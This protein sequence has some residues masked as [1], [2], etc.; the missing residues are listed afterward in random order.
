MCIQG[1]VIHIHSFGKEH[2]I[3]VANNWR[4]LSDVAEPSDIMLK[5]LHRIARISCS[6]VLC[7]LFLDHG[8]SSV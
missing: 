5:N 3:A 1:Y 8:V 7:L 2:C 6:V 4:R